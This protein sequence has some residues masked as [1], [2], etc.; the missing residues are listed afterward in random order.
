MSS[1]SNPTPRS[2]VP[3]TGMETGGGP[4][5]A[6]GTL[7][8]AEEALLRTAG[9]PVERRDVQVG[10]HRVHYLTC[11][12]GEPLLLLHGR[13][14]AA[15]LFAP[16]FA[17]LA[18]AHRVIALDLPGWG[19]SE[20]TPFSGHS[21][22]DALELWMS[23]ALGLLDA[24]GIERTDILGHSMGGFTA[25][26]LGLEHAE[27]VQRL[28]LVDSLGLS[29]RVRL[30]ERIEWWLKPE[31]LVRW[32]GPRALGWGL[33][34]ERDGTP[35]ARDERF[36]FLYALL[37]QEGM[38]ESGPRAFDQW[39]NLGGV[40]LDFTRRV[41]ELTMPTLLMWGDKDATTPYAD[42]LL[43]ARALG[44]GHLVAFTGCGHTPYEDRP[45]DFARTLLTW[46][47]VGRVAARV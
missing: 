15:A 19:L 36:A 47:E 40:H 42:A 20:K 26:G 34:S 13:V 2:S 10:G 6:E 4:S 31:R 16:I 30:D 12:E 8:F 7:A 22:H 29:S 11:G 14:G 32:L 18:A 28:V 45:A 9:V 1:L 44:P 23:G 17:P 3:L 37:T 39:V 33:R 35:V 21:A 41:R 38:V 24:L 46:L 5:S 27:R 25:M 43:A